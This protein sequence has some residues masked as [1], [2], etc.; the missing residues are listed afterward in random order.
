[1]DLDLQVETVE[2]VEDYLMLLELR[3]KIV[4]QIIIFLVVVEELLKLIL[5]HK[6]V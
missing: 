5:Y 1:V 3:D 2:Q 4:D 6:V